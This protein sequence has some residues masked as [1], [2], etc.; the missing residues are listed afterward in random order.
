[1]EEDGWVDCEKCKQGIN[2]VQKSRGKRG[3]EH[4]ISRELKTTI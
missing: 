1:M 4:E 3:K 2:T